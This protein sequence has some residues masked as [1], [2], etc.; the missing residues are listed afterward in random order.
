MTILGKTSRHNVC[1]PDRRGM[2]WAFK[3]TL[4]STNYY[5]GIPMG[6]ENAE[7]T[8][9]SSLYSKYGIMEKNFLFYVLPLLVIIL[10]MFQFIMKPMQGH[11]YHLAIKYK[12]L[13]IQ[14]KGARSLFAL[15]GSTD[16]HLILHSCQAKRLLYSTLMQLWV[17]SGYWR[18]E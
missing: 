3:S 14:N 5:W 8:E 9:R 11:L 6:T 2:S 15:T 18:A 17:A 4:C 12:H 1:D 7:Q 16:F 13:G 10:L